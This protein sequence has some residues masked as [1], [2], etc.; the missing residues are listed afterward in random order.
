MGAS[1]SKQS[2]IFETGQREALKQTGIDSTLAIPSRRNFGNFF[3]S[4]SPAKA[5][6]SVTLGDPTESGK[7]RSKGK[8]KKKQKPLKS[9]FDLSF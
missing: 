9:I 4:R 3:P 6:D 8:G 2:K 1:E 5:L 7:R